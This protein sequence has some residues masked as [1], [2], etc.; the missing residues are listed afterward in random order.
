M[1]E[2]EGPGWRVARDT[3]RSRFPVII[4]GEGWAI[5]L[6]E[7]EW[8]SLMEIIKD[9]TTQHKKLD[10]FLMPDESVCLEIEKDPWWG[11][12]DGTRSEW[13]LQVI[14]SGKG[15]TSRGIEGHW[16]NPAAQQIASAMRDIWDYLE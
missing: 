12:L 15:E 16:P 1:I 5:E 2:H 10:N 4:G 3:L 8:I 7:E 6:S 14:L 13:S 11:C 9:L